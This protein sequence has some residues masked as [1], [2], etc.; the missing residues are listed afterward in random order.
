MFTFKENNLLFVGVCG[1]FQID[2][3]RTRRE[4]KGARK[5]PWRSL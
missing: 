5:N 4:K 3:F 2:R 1:I